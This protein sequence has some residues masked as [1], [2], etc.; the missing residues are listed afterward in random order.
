MCELLALHFNQNI[1]PRFSLKGF[2]QRARVH[3]H[4]WGLA[5]FP[6]GEAQIIKEPHNAMRSS[7]FKA[8]YDGPWVKS[9]NVI[10]HLRYATHG[11]H[12]QQNT[13]PFM[14]YYQ[15]KS[16]VFAHNGV[17]NNH[18]T[19]SLNGYKPVGQTDSEHA[20]CHLLGVLKKQKLQLDKPE[21]YSKVEAVLKQINNLGKFNCIFSDGERL[22]A[23]HTATAGNSLHYTIRKAPFHAVS[24][25]DLDVSINLEDEKNP[26]TRGVVIATAAITDNEYWQVLPKGRLFVFKDGVCIFGETR[27]NDT[28]AHL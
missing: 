19:L 12:V 28:P 8:V 1:N 25:A 10:S 24:L 15:G 9:K 22:F 21:H 17:L 26:D 5:W 18:E 16:I 20:F 7:L 11:S 4:G 6:D 27:T 14:R 13:H 23:Y 3:S 2:Q